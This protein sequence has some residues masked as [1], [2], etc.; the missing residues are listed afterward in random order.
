M[1]WYL[2]ESSIPSDTSIIDA[3][4]KRDVSSEQYYANVE[5]MQYAYNKLN[6]LLFYN[7][8]PSNIKFSVKNLKNNMVGCAL[9]KIDTTSNQVIPISISL[10][11]KFKLTVHQW[12]EAMVHEMIHICDYTIN[13]KH[14]T[15]QGYDAHGDWFM[16]IGQKFKKFGFNVNAKCQFEIGN[17]EE[18]TID[19]MKEYST[20]ILFK[21]N[22][23]WMAIR[24]RPDDIDKF[25][26]SILIKTKKVKT[27]VL[28]KTKNPAANELETWDITAPLL[29]D[30][31]KV[32]DVFIDSYGPFISE[33][34]SLKNKY[35]S[36]SQDNV[37]KYIEVVKQIKGVVSA[38]RIDDKWCEVEIS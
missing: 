36:E 15:Q 10:N 20:F 38:K 37:D 6:Y 30:T 25:V 35:I 16:N 34:V 21:E 19:V 29:L 31:F 23:D 28:S 7:F 14:F 32:N 11:I 33:T 18:M 27:Y 8:L 5:F 1:K 3:S 2:L 4:I 22:N 17:N 9:Y 12:L 26:D 24:I 13:P